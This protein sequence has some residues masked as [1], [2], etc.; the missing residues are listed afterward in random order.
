MN[1]SELILPTHL[2]RR[3]VVYVRQFTPQQI[4]HNQESL[5]LQYALTHRAVELGWPEASIEVVDVDPGRSGAT[6]EGRVGFQELVA[7]AALGKSAF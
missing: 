3:A 1:T 6:T 5:K 2:T 4:T 7:E